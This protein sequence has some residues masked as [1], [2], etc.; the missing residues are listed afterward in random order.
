MLLNELK[1]PVRAG[2]E[3]IKLVLMR[4]YSFR[5]VSRLVYILLFNVHLS[6]ALFSKRNGEPNMI[7]DVH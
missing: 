3:V 2:P 5:V 4:C 1:K 6:P 7:K